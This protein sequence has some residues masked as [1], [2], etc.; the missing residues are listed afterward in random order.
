MK[1]LSNK[2]TVDFLTMPIQDVVEN[3]K[4]VA[5]NLECILND[6][7]YKLCLFGKILADVDIKK[8]IEETDDEYLKIEL[9]HYF[10]IRAAI[11]H[12]ETIYNRPASFI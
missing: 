12:L 10:A 11:Y 4:C 1:Q 3:L 5:N 9:Q 2:N 7:E 8:E 6:T